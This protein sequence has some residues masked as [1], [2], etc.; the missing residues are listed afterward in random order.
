M[1]VTHE[2]P[3]ESGYTVQLSDTEAGF[4]HRIIKGDECGGWVGYS[5]VASLHDA[6]HCTQYYSGIFPAEQLFRIGSGLNPI[7]TAPTDG[8]DFWALAFGDT[9]VIGQ[10]TRFVEETGD[11]DL[12]FAP[13][14]WLPA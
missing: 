10:R 12:T 7:E 9:R 3:H 4:A 6:R 5:D 2:F 11:F 13:T 8:Q 1:E 14:H